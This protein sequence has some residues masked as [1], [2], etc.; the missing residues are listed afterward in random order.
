M[1]PSSVAAIIECETDSRLR[2]MAD[3]RY[4]IKEAGG[5]VSPTSHLFEKRG[6]VVLEN[7]RCLT[8][9]DV[10]DQAIE[11]GATDIKLDEEGNIEIFT[12]PAQTM[13]A[14]RA[15]SGELG[16]DVK[17]SDIVWDPKEDS[18]VQAEDP[19]RLSSFLGRF[20]TIGVGICPES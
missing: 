9:E 15:L 17:S 10:F 8:E 2:T 18:M 16:I 14:A 3:L 1:L 4:L 5:S 12:E 6:R 20:D 19:D 11:A 13:A 7:P